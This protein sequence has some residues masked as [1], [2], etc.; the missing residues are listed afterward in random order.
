MIEDNQESNAVLVSLDKFFISDLQTLNLKSHIK[1]F[2][3]PCYFAL[4]F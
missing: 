1:K 4:Y 3:V 2:A